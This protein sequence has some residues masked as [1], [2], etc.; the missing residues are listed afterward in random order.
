MLRVED[1]V[2]TANN[3]Q[4]GV[5][6]RVGESVMSLTNIHRNLS[7]LIKFA[8]RAKIQNFLD[9]TDFSDPVCS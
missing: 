6:Q 5:D 4:V 1:E 3:D 8:V 9:Y 2:F 7:H